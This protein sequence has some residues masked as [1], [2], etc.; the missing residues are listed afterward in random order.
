MSHAAT[1]IAVKVA[2]GWLRPAWYRRASS[3]TDACRP[4][5][6]TRLLAKRNVLFADGSRE[7]CRG[8][9]VPRRIEVWV[10]FVAGGTGDG[11]GEGH[12]PEKH[13]YLLFR[14]VR[15]KK[16]MNIES[17]LKLLGSRV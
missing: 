13:F 8:D 11:D 10:R 4:L 9:Q 15:F 12:K 6:R 5:Q 7:V 1:H 14:M 3:K 2:T 17:I 16:E